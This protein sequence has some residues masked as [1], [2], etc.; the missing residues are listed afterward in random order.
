[1]SSWRDGVCLRVCF[2][3]GV[4]SFVNQDHSF[5]LIRVCMRVRSNHLWEAVSTL[6]KWLTLIISSLFAQWVI[7]KVGQNRIYTPY[8]TAY[9][10]ISLPRI[11]RLHHMCMVLANPRHALREVL[12]MMPIGML[13]RST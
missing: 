10:V 11:P 1:M 9:L 13:V 6:D 8:M 3:G 2:D 7:C 12:H 5:C 4:L